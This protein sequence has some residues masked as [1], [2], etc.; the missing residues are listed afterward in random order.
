MFAFFLTSKSL[1]DKI[2]EK[3]PT[4]QINDSTVILRHLLSPARRIII[5][6]FSVC[7][8]VLV[9]LIKTLDFST[10]SQM[11]YRFTQIVMK[12]IYNQ[13]IGGISLLFLT[14]IKYKGV[15]FRVLSA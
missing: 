7:H 13:T 9:N 11:S 14:V 6:N 3:H 8:A 12:L 10:S 15:N 2:V 1:V 4:I 5:S